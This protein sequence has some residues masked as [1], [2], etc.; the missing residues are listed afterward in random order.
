MVGAMAKFRVL[1][2]PDDIVIKAKTDA[3]ALARLYESYYDR[4]YRFCV[5][6]LFSKDAA[7]DLTSVIFLEMARA[8][9]TFPGRTE[10]D[11]Q[12][13]LYAI[14]ANH[15]NAYIRKTSRQKV[16]FE[17]MAISRA[18]CSASDSSALDWSVLYAAIA[19]LKPK[20]QT[21]VTL[22]FFENMEFEQIAEIVNASEVFVRVTL[23]RA[24]RKLRAYLHCFADGEI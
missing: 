18:A 2:N 14:A 6:R 16:L 5:Y 15:A 17:K 22:R 23:H 4:I 7:E 21:I 12:N 20:H 3:H 19:R 13:W 10:K 8:I 1:E 9:R 24:L 11:F